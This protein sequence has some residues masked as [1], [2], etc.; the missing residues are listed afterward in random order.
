MQYEENAIQLH[1]LSL[2]LKSTVCLS[3]CLFFS[4]CL[5][6]HKV[7][8]PLSSHAVCQ[9]DG[10]PQPFHGSHHHIG[11]ACHDP[12]GPSATMPWWQTR[13]Q[14]ADG[15][16]AM[17]TF[18][19][20]WCS[21]QPG[22]AH[23]G[24]A[25]FPRV[26]HNRKD[27]GWSWVMGIGMK[28]LRAALHLG[29]YLGSFILILKIQCTNLEIWKNW[30]K[31]SNIIWKIWNIEPN[32]NWKIKSSGVSKA[33]CSL[34]EPHDPFGWSTE[35]VHRLILWADLLQCPNIDSS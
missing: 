9:S 26:D 11:T 20:G 28:G 8:A 33:F 25:A 34:W 4:F 18:K 5:L 29:I 30:N 21:W 12:L 1:S 7:C 2:V 22:T 32:I 24:Q 13:C 3:T 10:K 31:K 16:L 19:G 15:H 23:H 14:G 17:L 35:L 27:K 6:A